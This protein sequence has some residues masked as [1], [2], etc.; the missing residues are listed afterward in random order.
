MTWD[1]FQ[2]ARRLLAE[3]TVGVPHRAAQL[4]EKQKIDETKARIRKHQGI[5]ADGTVGM[6]RADSS[7][8]QRVVTDVAG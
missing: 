4:L 6:V 5:T 8:P 1:Q 7:V 3:E 2:R